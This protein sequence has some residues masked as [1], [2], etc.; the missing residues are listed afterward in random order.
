VTRSTFSS[1][2]LAAVAA[3]DALIP[4][5]ITLHELAVGPVRVVEARRLRE[6][7]GIVFKTILIVDAM[8]L[9]AA[10][11]ALVVRVPSVRSLAGHLF[12]MR[13]LIDRRV[14]DTLQWCDARDMNADCHTKG[15]VLRDAFLALMSGVY[16]AQHPTKEFRTKRLSAE[17]WPAQLVFA[18]AH[19]TR[20]VC[21]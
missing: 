8:S 18:G 14:L 20:E 5:A 6:E 11:S 19:P 17:G 12:W 9:F 4:L 7:G 16:R 2:T 1:E 13:E 15:S 10:V 21:T 3:L